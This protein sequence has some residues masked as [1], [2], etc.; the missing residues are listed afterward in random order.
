LQLQVVGGE[1]DGRLLDFRCDKL[2]VGSAPHATFRLV[3][4]GAAPCELLIF[5]GSHGVAVR[6]GSP[7]NLLNGRPFTD[8]FLQAGDLLAV[9]P[10]QFRVMDSAAGQEQA[11]AEED[12]PQDTA[13]PKQARAGN[14][15][16]ATQVLEELTPS[17]AAEL[18]ETQTE[19]N[20]LRERLGEYE[21]D[22]QCDLE[23]W[24][25]EREQWIDEL[26]DSRQQ[27]LRASKE[28]EEA[29]QSWEA[30]R[31]EMRCELEQIRKELD[32]ALTGRMV[33]SDNDR[34]KLEKLVSQF[35]ETKEE[36]DQLAGQVEQANSRIGELEST[37]QTFHEATE[38]ASSA[39]VEAEDRIRELEAELA[40]SREQ[41]EAKA[42]DGEPSEEQWE[43]YWRKLEELTE[44]EQHLAEWAGQLEA[45]ADRLE[46]QQKEIHAFEEGEGSDTVG[47]TADVT[48]AAGE[49]EEELAELLRMR[50]ELDRRHE[51]LARRE[52]LLEKQERQPGD[53][54]AKAIMDSGRTTP[55][56]IAGDDP[57]SNTIPLENQDSLAMSLAQRYL[58]DDDSG[59]AGDAQDSEE[60]ID[61]VVVS[62]QGD[63]RNHETLD[64][65][66]DL[67][68]S[69]P[70]APVSAAAIMAKYTGGGE[71]DKTE[72]GD[73]DSGQPAPVAADDGGG[74]SSAGEPADEDDSI[75]AYMDQLMQRVRGD[76]P[77]MPDVAEAA[78][79]EPDPE[80]VPESQ[81]ANEASKPDASMP[82][83]VM[84]SA[85][86]LP[87]SSAP[88]ETDRLSQMREVANAT[89]SS[90]IHVATRRRR[91]RAA[92][93]HLV[94]AAAAAVAGGILVAFSTA[95]M[96]LLRHLT[97]AVAWGASAWWGYRAV[98]FAVG[99]H[100]LPA[101]SYLTTIVDPARKGDRTQAVSRD[102]SETAAAE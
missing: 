56:A 46:S 89:A 95:D 75:R 10:F 4:C 43:S 30:E 36:R 35:E 34:E 69:D 29:N 31:H 71:D 13:V 54:P 83:D 86:F 42:S 47:Q 48:A 63:S 1:Y 78:P 76:S 9:G 52:A 15:Y 24:Q 74:P 92:A 51:E 26:A 97:A 5:R 68:Q 55:S 91:A 20:L 96:P 41:A 100:K 19:L 93:I 28:L 2:S 23:Q 60:A 82:F 90:A 67:R 73:N 38:A 50:E 98:S 72:A 80:T 7:R 84:S 8:A 65:E 59:Q 79:C 77:R 101:R 11:P 16:P 85:E 53:L 44:R 32:E 87:R 94:M 70:A 57:G 21:S 58:E 6:N 49:N 102:D 64:V 45:E 18:A 3:G 40:E 39:I 17:L 27:T 22:A 66:D 61:E 14:G 25:R 62:D 81:A 88:E 99:R 12:C 33:P 37:C